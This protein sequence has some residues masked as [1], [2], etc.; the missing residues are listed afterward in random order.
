VEPNA[1]DGQLTAI[2]QEN[3]DLPLEDVALHLFGGDRAPLTTPIACGP[4]DTDALFTPWSAPEAPSVSGQDT[5][6]TSRSPAGGC[7]TTEQQAPATFGFLAGTSDPMAGAYSSFTLHIARSDGT[8][9]LAALETRLPEG[10]L[11]RLAGVPYCSDAAIAYASSLN[12]PLQ[13]ALEQASPSCGAASEIGRVAVGAGSGPAPV[14]ANGVA[15][16]A[17]PYKGAPLSLAI[18]T[19]AI[20]GPFD[21]GNV[22]TRVALYVEPYSAQIRAVSDPLPTILQ[23]I[24]LDVRSVSLT[25][26]RPDFVV[27]PTSC[28][29]KSVDGSASTLNGTTVPL[30]QYFQVGRCESLRFKP[31]LNLTLTG[32]T[33]RAGHP[34]LKAV[35]TYPRQGAYANIARAQVGLPPS[36]FLDQ[37]NLDNVCRQADLMAGTCPRTSVYGH[38]KAW[39]PL[40]E[41]RLEGPVYLGVGFGYK[42]PALVADLNGQVRILL[43]GRVDSTPQNGIRNTF[44]T[45]PD[46]PVSRFVLELKGGR[47][48]GLFQNSEDICRTEQ[49][50]NAVFRA[51]NG[52]LLQSH[53]LIR[54]RCTH[55]ARHR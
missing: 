4:H 43:K 12:Q 45:V 54:N 55:R 40:L 50:A 28:D 42:L 18:M 10:L 8:Q 35:V 30:S 32:Q 31:H 39:S 51:Q 5:F 23:G 53:P 27:N 26:S 7:V 46:A 44:E 41:H 49:R 17:G 21:L 15:Y 34:A 52:L 25:L 22:V 14:Y 47:R 2:F 9:R 38:A 48:Y 13:G 6:F 1:T 37:G 19:P 33:K 20:A 29:P 36:E 16:L 3:P 11:G 24:P